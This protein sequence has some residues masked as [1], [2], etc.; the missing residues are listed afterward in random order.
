MPRRTL[1]TSKN[2]LKQI[3]TP[4][5]GGR[6]T[7]ISHGLIIDTIE[8]ELTIAG[9][10]ISKEFYRSTS[11][12]EIATGILHLTKSSDPDISMMFSWTNSY[13]KMVRFM[14][15]AGAYVHANESNI[16]GNNLSNFARKHTGTADNEAVET[17]QDQISRIDHYFNSLVKDKDLMKSSTLTKQE[18]AELA[19]RIFIEKEIINKEQLGIV[20]DQLKKTDF[21][22]NSDSDS[23]WAFY[24]HFNY[25]L[26]NG[27]PKTWMVQ[28]SQVHRFI[29]RIFK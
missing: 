23:Y 2:E 15:V 22:Y 12:G 13:N 7:V 14:S 18:Q 21:N 24:N 29:F 4:N 9:L 1:V 28:Q 8:Q 20:R 6:Y 10:N 26:R 5:H 19:G 17:I 25:A 27:H 16:V 11:D 3:A